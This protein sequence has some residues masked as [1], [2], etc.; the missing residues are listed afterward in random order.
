[1]TRHIQRYRPTT[2]K[3]TFASEQNL[4]SRVLPSLGVS[5]LDS[6]ALGPAL[7]PPFF[8]RADVCSVSVETLWIETV[9]TF[10]PVLPMRAAVVASVGAALALFA[11]ASLSPAPPRA[12]VAQMP[13]VRAPIAASVAYSRDSLAVLS[14]A[15]SLNR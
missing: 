1:M 6:K 4:R 2:H 3:R 7:G 8:R 9:L 12:S 10:H 5:S 13:P 11:L 14:R 15:D